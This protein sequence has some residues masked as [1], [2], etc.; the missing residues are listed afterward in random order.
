[1]L[2]LASDADIHGDVIRGLRRRKPGLDLV[3]VQDVGLRTADD[4]TILEWAATE[5]RVLITRDRKTLVGTAYQRVKAGLPLPGVIVFRHRL[6]IGQAIE[7]I[8]T[9]ASCSTEDEMKDRVVFLPL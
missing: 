3:R 9:V 6:S 1:M 4:A 8:L 7:E 5:G 2:R